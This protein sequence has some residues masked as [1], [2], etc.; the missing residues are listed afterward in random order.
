[1]GALSMIQARNADENPNASTPRRR[2]CAR[3]RFF[4]AGFGV[5]RK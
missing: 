3:P 1:M 4:D 5:E 2:T